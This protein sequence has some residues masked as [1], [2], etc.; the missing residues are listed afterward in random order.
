MKAPENCLSCIRR[1]NAG[2]LARKDRVTVLGR[3]GDEAPLFPSGNHVG[4][5]PISRAEALNPV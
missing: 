4:C 5:G 1:L 2:R 3:C